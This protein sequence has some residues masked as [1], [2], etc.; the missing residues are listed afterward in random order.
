MRDSLP[1]LRAPGSNAEGTPVLREKYPMPSQVQLGCIA[2]SEKSRHQVL[3]FRIFSTQHFIFTRGPIPELKPFGLNGAALAAFGDKP[4][5]LV[6]LPLTESEVELSE[7]GVKLGESTFNRLF[8]LE[9][10]HSM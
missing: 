9:I 6:E 2:F 10:P 4:V 3:I 1:L 7:A 8:I 5:A